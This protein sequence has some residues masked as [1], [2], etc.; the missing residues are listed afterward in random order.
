M[1]K[2]KNIIAY[3]HI[4]DNTI[5]VNGSTLL[6]KKSQLSFAE[7]SKQVY[8]EKT[9]AYPKFFKMDNLSKLAF[10]A[11]EVLLEN[12]S[13]KDKE[14]MAIV[15]S[16]KSSSLDTDKKHQDAINDK[17]NYF[18]SPAVFVYTLPNIAI[19]EISIRHQIKGENAFF[20]SNTFNEKLISQY[21]STLIQNE[22]STHILC[23]WVDFDDDK[24]HAFMYLVA[25]DGDHKYSQ[26]FIK[27]IYN[28]N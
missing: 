22:K 17:E 20:V 5:S 9:I 4:K 26:E 2:N 24:Y 7:F 27:K 15:L 3:C 25:E 14:N 21:A 10:L 11:S 16:N 28:E 19:G 8:K 1:R 18:P 23:G 6:T 13:S 12:I